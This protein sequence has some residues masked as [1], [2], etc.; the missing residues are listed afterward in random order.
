MAE[1]LD[2][3]WP[4]AYERE[5]AARVAA[6]AR[7]EELTTELTVLRR[8]DRLADLFVCVEYDGADWFADL[9]EPARPDVTD[10]VCNRGPFVSREACEE[11][12]ETALRDA[13]LWGE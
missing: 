10:A 4:E 13:G 12:A 3:A 11:A 5:H 1:K 7:V 9:W 6:E 2:W 8:R